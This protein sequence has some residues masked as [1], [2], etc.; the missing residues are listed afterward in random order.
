MAAP[1]FV[2]MNALKPII[3][4]PNID[5]SVTCDEDG[6][7]VLRVGGFYKD[8]HI[9][10]KAIPNDRPFVD[11]TVE[12]RGRYDVLETHDMM[13]QSGIMEYSEALGRLVEKP[14]HYDID[15]VA[16]LVALNYDRFRSWNETKPEFDKFDAGWLPR[17]L[18][19][20][21]VK[22]KTVTTYVAA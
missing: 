21:L 17:L 16:A 22:T 6:E 2:L 19:A 15:L 5:T 12:I 18:E 14:S 9:T 20:G 7:F 11:F 4:D 13:I 10:V 3:A 1:F 8:G